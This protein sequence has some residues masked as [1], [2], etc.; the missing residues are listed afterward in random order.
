MAEFWRDYLCWFVR[1]KDDAR[2]IVVVLNIFSVKGFFLFFWW[3][4]LR[5]GNRKKKWKGTSSTTSIWTWWKSKDCI[6]KPS[7]TLKRYNIRIQS[8]NFFLIYFIKVSYKCDLFW[9]FDVGANIKEDV[10]QKKFPFFPGMSQ[11]WNAA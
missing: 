1:P 5:N 7:K 10:L 6:S 9:C 8:N 3:S 4:S 11:K 2:S